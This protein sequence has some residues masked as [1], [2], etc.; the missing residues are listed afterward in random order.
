MVKFVHEY[1]DRN[2]PLV[3]TDR[4]TNNITV[5]FKMANHTVMWHFYQG[6]DE[7]N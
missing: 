6:N 1:T 4:I 3:Y 5:E 7:L 2:N